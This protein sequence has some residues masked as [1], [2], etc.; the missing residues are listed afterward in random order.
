MRQDDLHARPLRF[1][2]ALLLFPAVHQFLQAIQERC[3]QGMDA[4]AS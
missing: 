3:V 2:D 4:L 1:A